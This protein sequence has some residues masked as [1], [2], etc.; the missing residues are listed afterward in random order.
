M[1]MGKW[2]QKSPA[3]PAQTAHMTLANP[4]LGF[5]LPHQAPSTRHSTLASAPSPLYHLTSFSRG[6]LYPLRSSRLGNEELSTAS[7]RVCL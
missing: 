4:L 6:L 7:R 5:Q 2:C 1:K 3:A